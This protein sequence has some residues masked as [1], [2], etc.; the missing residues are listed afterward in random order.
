[1][2]SMCLSL[3]LTP[4]SRYTSWISFTRYDCSAFSPSTF[5]MSCGFDG[6]SINGSP[7][8]TRSPSCTLTW[9]P[10][11]SAY[12]R[13]SAPGSSGT[14][15]ILRCPLTMPPCLTTP[16]ISEMTAVSRGLRASNSSTTRGRPPVMSLVF[17][18]FLVD[19]N[20]FEDVLEADLARFL[21]E[22]RERV[23][24]PFDQDLALLDSLAF[25]DLE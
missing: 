8:R 12:S 19:G 17:V 4:C 25:L 18:D 6:P 9:T 2:T 13:G 5:R 14:M 15:M 22:D 1:M 21:G 7:A 10:R 23:G 20:A 16:S 3:M 11:G 24:I